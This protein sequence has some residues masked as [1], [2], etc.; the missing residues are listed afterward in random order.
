MNAY[1]LN[2]V[3]GYYYRKIICEYLSISHKEIYKTVKNID[4]NTNI[5]SLHDGRK[6]KINVSEVK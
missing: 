4:Y 2:S 3:S 6:L 5:I 1:K